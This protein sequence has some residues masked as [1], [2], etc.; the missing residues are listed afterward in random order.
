MQ[1]TS[2]CSVLS[3]SLAPS[4]AWIPKS[5]WT[6]CPQT[7]YRSQT[8]ESTPAISG[9]SDCPLPHLEWGPVASHSLMPTLLCWGVSAVKTPTY[10]LHQC[11]DPWADLGH[12]IAPG[13]S[14]HF[15]VWECSPTHSHT[16][17][18]KFQHNPTLGIKPPQDQGPLLP[19]WSG[20]AILCYIGIQS[21]G[22][23]QVHSLVDGL[24]SGRTGWSDQPMLFFQWGYKPPELFF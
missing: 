15:P 5:L 9:I 16:P 24:D 11:P 22:S 2:L 21:H 17:V 19:L 23:L 13:P 6:W 4:G 7:P 3:S 8:S 12:P 20:K 1:P 18:L 14:S 10:H